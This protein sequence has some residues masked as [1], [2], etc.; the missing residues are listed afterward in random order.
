MFS[1]LP[2]SLYIHFPWCVRKCPYCDFNSH[3]LNG[4]LDEISY[5][6]ALLS[7][8][9]NDR[10]YV[11]DRE[12]VSIFM[13]GGTP[14][15]FSAESIQRL[16]EGI[17]LKLNLAQ[18]CEVTMEMNPGGVEH[19]NLSG[20][21]TAGINRLSIGIQSFQPEQLKKLG[22]VHNKTEAIEIVS[23]VKAAGFTNINLDLMYALPQQNVDEALSDLQQAIDLQ[24]QHLSWYH[25]TI[26]P[27]TE[28]YRRP[29]I[30]P[31]EDTSIAIETT[32]KELLAKMGFHQYEISAYSKTPALQ[33]RH[34]CN[35][36]EFGDYLGIGAGA[37]SKITDLTTGKI[38]RYTKQRTPNKYLTN[39]SP[40]ISNERL[41][42][43]QDKI[44]EFMFNTLRLTAG[45][46]ADLFTARTGM[47]QSTLSAL[48]IKAQ[49]QG[50]LQ[51][52]QNRIAP[53]LLGQQF[54]N[55]LLGIFMT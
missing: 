48:L 52:E 28:F 54:L 42:T 31:D 27:N 15:L 8:L 39:R 12:I 44:I 46:P 51:I 40:F 10:Q 41:L 2:L 49:Q 45:F 9:D 26:E 5:I 55:E 4:K 37:H 13:G 24:P 29:P 19:G 33:A 43:E 6:N 50:F 35:Y 23:K 3:A 32:G 1:S 11:Q 22:R 36:W 21:R 30:L 34:N 38:T 47:A 7:D 25:L 18:D 17:R 53:T 20:Y 14:S 16:M